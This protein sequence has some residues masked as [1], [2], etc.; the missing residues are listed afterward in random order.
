[1]IKEKPYSSISAQVK[2]RGILNL[3]INGRLDSNSTG[4]LWREAMVAV[5]HTSPK[6][7]IVDASGIS[8]CDGSGI[9]L[10]VKLREIQ[11]KTGGKF[12]I[13]SFA[14]EFQKLLD[15]FPPRGIQG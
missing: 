11:E 7:V 5:E 14:S 4:K 3:T 6:Q 10:F 15:L 12:E 1:M 2:E 13:R 9:A 8:Y